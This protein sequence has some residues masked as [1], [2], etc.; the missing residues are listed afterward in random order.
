MQNHTQFNDLKT[1]EHTD[2]SLHFSVKISN[3]LFKKEK[4]II[5][6]FAS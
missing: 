4:P 1:H 5:F 2:L 6:E 3:L